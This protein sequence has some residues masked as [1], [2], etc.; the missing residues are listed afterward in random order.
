M[1]TLLEATLFSKLAIVSNV[2]DMC[3]AMAHRDIGLLSTRIA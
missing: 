1:L 3:K 2:S